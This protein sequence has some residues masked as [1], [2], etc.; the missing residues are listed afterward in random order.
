MGEVGLVFWGKTGH[1]KGVLGTGGSPKGDNEHW[2]RGFEYFG[3]IIA[4]VA[5]QSTC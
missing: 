4:V 2:D 3:D 1:R 5:W